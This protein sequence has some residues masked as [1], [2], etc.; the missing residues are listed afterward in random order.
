MVAVEFEYGGGVTGCGAERRHE[1]LRPEENPMLNRDEISH[2]RIFVLKLWDA[3]GVPSQWVETLKGDL[4][5]RWYRI[6]RYSDWGAL[7]AEASATFRRSVTE[8]ESVNVCEHNRC[9]LIQTTAVRSED[10]AAAPTA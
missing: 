2:G 5:R 3:A 7:R 10:L 8:Q 6:Y 4:A 9:V 1:T